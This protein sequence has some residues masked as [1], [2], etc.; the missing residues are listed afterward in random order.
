MLDG[1]TLKIHP[2]PCI[3]AWHPWP[4]TASECFLQALLLKQVT[5]FADQCKLLGANQLE[6]EKQGIL[7]EIDICFLMASSSE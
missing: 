2:W 6:Y 4:L 3:N 7:G 1:N 5:E